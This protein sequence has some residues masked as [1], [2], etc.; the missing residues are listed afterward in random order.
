MG[1]VGYEKKIIMKFKVYLAILIFGSFFSKALSQS[2]FSPEP[3]KFLKDV[4]LFI[5]NYNKTKAKKYVNSFE[6]LWLGDFFT[7]DNRSL[8]YA[9]LNSMLEKKL[10]VYPDFISYFDAIYNYSNSGMSSEKFQKW[11][12]ILDNVIKKYNNKRVQ[13]FLKVSNNLFLDGTIYVTSRTQKAATRWQVSKKDSF[14]IQL[15]KKL[16]VFVFH[17]VDLKCFSKNDSSVIYNTSGEFSPLTSSWKGDGGKIDWQRA[18]KDKDI[19][20]AKINSYN[21]SLKSSSYYIDS[22]LFYSSY[23]DYPIMGELTE[24]IIAFRGYTKVNYPV[25]ESYSK[26]LYIKN[27][28]S[29]TNLDYE[30]GF[31]IRGRNLNGSGTID[32]LAKLKFSYNDKE[33]LVAE[34]INF[35]INDEGVISNKAKIKF[36]LGTDSIS[37]PATNLVF[38]ENTKTLTLSREEDGVFAAPFYNSYHKIDMYVETLNWKSGEHTI[39][40]SAPKGTKS[41]K[42]AQFS[43][44]NF[45]DVKSYDNLNT[46]RGNILV[47]IKRYATIFGSNTF[48]VNNLA[49]YLVKSI[50]DLQFMLFNL[51]EKGFVNYDSE[52]K[53]II[54][55]EKLFNYIENRSGEKDYDIM[56][57]NSDAE[58]NA[59]LSLS[60]L[61]LNIFGVERVVLSLKNK[62]WI[63]PG[64]RRLTL[65]K[66]RD[67]NFD[68][69]ITAGKTQY[70]GFDF[71]FI[72]KDFKLNLPKCDSMFIWA[73]Y[74]E[75][76]RKGKLIRLQSKIETLEGYVQID[77]P[78]NK[79]GLDT[80]HHEYPILNSITKT[81]VYYDDPSIQNGLYNRENFKFIVNPFLIDSLDNFKDNGINLSGLFLSGGIFPDFEESLNIMPDYS[82]GFIRNTPNDGFKI[83]DQL[84]SYDNEIRLSNDGLKGSGTI[85]FYT[86]TAISD[87]ITFFPDSVAAIAHTYDNKEQVSDP[88]IPL[89]GG[90]DCKVSYIPKENLLY[91]HSIDSNFNF[92]EGG[93]AILKGRLKLGYNGIIGSGIM[94]FGSGEVE[95]FN[96]TYETDAILADTCEFRLVSQ[97]SNL[98][99]LSFKTQNLNARVD[100]E[101]RMGEFKS[102][103]GESFV[104]FPENEYICYM[105]QFNW[106]M[107]SDDL[108]MENSKQ[109]QSDI[110]IDTDLDLQTSNFFSINK[111]QDSLNF[112]SAKARFDIK[113]K[114]IICNEIKFIKVADSRI[115]PDSGKIIIRRK[116]KIDPLENAFILTN[117]ITKYYEIY[118]ADVE[119]NSKHD[120][121]ATGIYDFID[122]NG[123]KQNIFFSEMRPDTTDQTH[124]TGFIKKNK[125]FKLSPNFNFYGD[126]NLV[127]TNPSLEFSGFTQIVHSCKN[128]PQQWI[129][130]SSNIDPLDILIPIELDSSNKNSNLNNIFSGIIFNNT[131][132]LSLYSSF[133]SSKTNDNHVGMINADGFLKYNSKRKE[134]QLS[135]SEKLIEY[136]LPGNYTALNIENCRLKSDGIFDFAV[137][138]DQ[139]SLKPAGEIKFNPKK[140]ETD[141]K[142]STI[143][144]FH[145][146]ADALDK[147]ARDI[148]EFPEL[149]SLDY[150][151]SYYEKALSEFTSKDESNEMISSL[152]I[153]GKI[154]KFPEKLE[155]PL[156]LGDI[157]YRWNSNRKAYVSYG[158]IGIANIYKRQIMKYVKGKIVIS[159]KLTGNEITVYLQLGKD[160]FYY[161]NYKK[162][163][164]TT[165]SSNEDFNKTISESKK[166]ETKSKKKGKQ[167]YQYVLGASKYVA[168]FVAT[169]MK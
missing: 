84:A 108:E 66:N 20:Y 17:G 64:G 82:L 80:S 32:N 121:I 6:T 110:N 36:S 41:I 71:S 153:N 113:K 118:D 72:Y 132:S 129:G 114:R 70:Y 4:Q 89:I 111:E 102:N 161:F 45:F 48:P 88:Q 120:Y 81:Y 29:N 38:S 27:V 23:F 22:V 122:I 33:F 2:T 68:G 56:T 168:P 34:S 86:S 97:N 30:G 151:N 54:C 25:F 55:N 8:V 158:D 76:K 133:L 104:T 75:S 12:N 128:I 83:Y 107:D 95:S 162:G 155:V 28:N 69:L 98:D 1:I 60:S 49:K 87:N 13:D 159:R 142:T 53:I 115:V 94:R 131:D 78:S 130:F 116:A 138:L 74:K 100:F 58:T 125:D 44:L 154:K 164:M 59:K 117:D 24:K 145:F 50:N 144:D 85:E 167:D 5:G 62:V 163:L 160:N 52:R 166:D 93:Q 79:S 140:W 73:N 143:L 101:T 169:Y 150:Q 137:D 157:R 14:D 61:D 3:E 136:T 9:T 10:R 67:L 146:S 40:F 109:A 149:R 126:V 35:L 19:Y 77:D 51:A 92:F 156:F 63:K 127:S 16:P 57:I 96:Y 103:S 165:F 148:I 47:S 105:D 147:L 124:G 31:T 135:N 90:K 139:I 46:D 43:S 65:K 123:T 11:N 141:F 39:N 152:N 119:I 134:Y 15:V 18:R 7:P 42:T 99:E 21:I 37:H 106:Y 26:R 91:A 112:G